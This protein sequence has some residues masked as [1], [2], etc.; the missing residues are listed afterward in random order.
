MKY[1]TLLNMLDHA[2]LAYS[3]TP[4]SSEFDKVIFSD[5]SHIGVQYYVGKGEKTLLIAFRGTDSF[6][7]FITDI[8]CNKKTVPYNNTD[9]KIQVHTGFIGAYKEDCVRGEIHKLITPEIKKIYITGHSYGA[10]LAV[11]CAVDLQY[12]YPERFFE[13]VLFGCP[14]VGN[15]WFRKSYNKRLIKTLRVEN[16]NDAITKLP[17]ACMGYRHVGIKI[18]IGGPR[19][20]GILSIRQHTGQR[21]YERLWKWHG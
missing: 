2:M 14:R 17:F 12:H 8:K 18:N 19:I 13:V 15:R 6:M 1:F 10:A 5:C 16:G 21:Y 3:D 7:D 9:S 11:L 4:T 20:L